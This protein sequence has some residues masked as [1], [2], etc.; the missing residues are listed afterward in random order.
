MPDSVWQTGV[1]QQ[2]FNP[3]GVSDAGRKRLRLANFEVLRWA[4]QLN[5]LVE[6]YVVPVG[7]QTLV[8]ADLN[9]AERD[10]D[11]LR[12]FGFY[13]DADDVVI[14]FHQGDGSDNIFGLHSFGVI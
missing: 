12:E 4:S 3:V 14:D 8:H 1:L 2:V 10:I 5:G 7:F 9:T 11:L 6:T 13:G